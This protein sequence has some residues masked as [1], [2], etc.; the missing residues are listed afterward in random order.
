[1]EILL[2]S[3]ATTAAGCRHALCEQTSKSHAK[4]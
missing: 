2:F 4:G 1:M 3:G